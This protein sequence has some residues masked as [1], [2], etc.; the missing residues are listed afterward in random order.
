MNASAFPKTRRLLRRADFSRA[1]RCGAGVRC[2][3][4]VLLCYLRQDEQNARLGIV[5]SRKVGNAV[6]RNRAKRRVRE[7]FRTCESLPK[8]SDWVVILYPPASN[9]ET[10]Q[11]WQSLDKALPRALRKAHKAFQRRQALHPPETS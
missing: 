4:F 11:L 3:H 7:W 10:G 6:V 8:G 2:R 9:D 1:Q 5:A